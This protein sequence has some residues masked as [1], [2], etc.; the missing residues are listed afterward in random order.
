MRNLIAKPHLSE[1]DNYLNVKTIEAHIDDDYYVRDLFP[2]DFSL[3][4]S[5]ATPSTGAVLVSLPAGSEKIDVIQFSEGNTDEVKATFR[6]RQYWE[7]G[8]VEFTIYYSGSLG[9]SNNIRWS[10]RGY[11]HAVGEDITATTIISSDEVTPGPSTAYYLSKYTFSTY[12]PFSREKELMNIKILRISGNAA[13]TYTG[14]A[15]LV[16]VKARLVPAM[17]QSGNKL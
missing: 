11:S 5:A 8:N 14:D 9:S 15:Y 12:L 7:K 13:D 10:L 1:N 3:T 17:L 4:G 16:M 6:S 2:T